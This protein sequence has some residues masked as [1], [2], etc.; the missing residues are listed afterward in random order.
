MDK[1]WFSR[2]RYFCLFLGTIVVLIVCQ[3]ALAD[4]SGT[5]PSIEK[6]FSLIQNIF[7]LIENIWLLLAGALVFFMN[8]GFALLEAGLCRERNSINVLAKT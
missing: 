7:G 2:F 8:A 5:E 4:V 3:T 6:N 1:N